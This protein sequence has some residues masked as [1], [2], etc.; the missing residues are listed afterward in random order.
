MEIFCTLSCGATLLSAYRPRFLTDPDKVLGELGATNM[1]ATPSMAAVLKAER[2]GA[3]PESKFSALANVRIVEI[4]EKTY[5]PVAD[6]LEYAFELWTMGEK[7]SDRVIAE[8]DRA[9][10]FSVWNAYVSR[11]GIFRTSSS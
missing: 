6:D 1:M 4:R 7:L 2:I 5:G 10:R 9:P 3:F 11:L 8:F